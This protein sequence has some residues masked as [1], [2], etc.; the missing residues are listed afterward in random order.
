MNGRALLV[1][2]LAAA[3]TA[4]GQSSAAKPWSAP[5]TSFGQPDIQGLW[6]TTTITP[7]ERPRDLAGKQFFTEQ[8]AAAY[9]KRMVEGRDSNPDAAESVADPVV[10]WERGVHIV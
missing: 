4:A 8:E 1:L 6:N 2:G 5:R 10:W 7:L 9:E 3:A